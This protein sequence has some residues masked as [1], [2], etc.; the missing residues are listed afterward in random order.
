MNI[1]KTNEKSAWEVYQN[2]Q[3]KKD[4]YVAYVRDVISEE[5][6]GSGYTGSKAYLNDLWGIYQ[7]LEPYEQKKL[8]TTFRKIQ[9]SNIIEK[10]KNLKEVRNQIEDIMRHLACIELIHQK[11]EFLTG[12]ELKKP[13][14]LPL[15]YQEQEV[16][17]TKKDIRDYLKEKKWE[18]VIDYEFY[19]QSLHSELKETELLWKAYQ[20][21]V[22]LVKQK[23]E[24]KKMEQAFH[25]LV[26]ERQYLADTL[27][28]I[29]TPEQMIT[30]MEYV[31][32]HVLVLQCSED[33]HQMLTD[34]YRLA[35][36]LV[37]TEEAYSTVIGDFL[38]KQYFSFLGCT[39]PLA[40]EALLNQLLQEWQVQV[41]ELE[42]QLQEAEENFQRQFFSSYFREREYEHYSYSKINDFSKL[43]IEEIRK[44]FH[45]YSYKQIEKEAFED[46]M[47]DTFM[48]IMRMIETTFPSI[49]SLAQEVIEAFYAKIK[50]LEQLIE[51]EQIIIRSIHFYNF[52]FFDYSKRR[53]CLEDGFIECRHEISDILYNIFYLVYQ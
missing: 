24:M 47:Q 9:D 7:C 5:V 18:I 16:D 36:E 17:I 53:C 25:N 28:S 8:Y 40:D 50:S 4:S 45:T 2:I 26:V 39:I 46:A 6:N 34:I 1:F 13:T 30:W 10:S 42:R 22:P 20:A 29:E 23:Q 19:N 31:Y 51:E 44:Y 14:Q 12:K 49:T 43:F 48:K 27:N 3:A 33:R 21:I 35:S 52:D 41:Q 11:L 32:D 37:S 38:I 15:L